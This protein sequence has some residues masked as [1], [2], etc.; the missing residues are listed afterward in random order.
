MKARDRAR[1]GCKT[2]RTASIVGEVL[3]VAQPQMMRYHTYLGVDSF[4]D[5]CSA[6]SWTALQIYGFCNQGCVL[7]LTDTGQTLEMQPDDHIVIDNGE[8]KRQDN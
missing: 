8:L 5:S 6:S 3:F 1:C 2:A 4:S 7:K